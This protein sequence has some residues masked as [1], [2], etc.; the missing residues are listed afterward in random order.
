CRT[1]ARRR[2]PESPTALRRRAERRSCRE[3]I[4]P[5]LTLKII[6]ADAEARRVVA[7]GVELDRFATEAHLH[8]GGVANNQFI[9]RHAVQRP[10]GGFVNTDQQL[11][12]GGITHVD[13]RAVVELEC[14]G[15]ASGRG[16]R[17]IACRTGLLR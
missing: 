10:R 7:L 14:Q 1:P 3:W 12:T 17:C 2:D 13:P 15:G 9:R 8:T 11:L 4:E 5:V 6:L 16:R